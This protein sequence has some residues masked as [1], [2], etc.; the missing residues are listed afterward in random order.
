MAIHSKLFISKTLAELPTPFASPS[1]TS[2]CSR[3][4]ALKPLRGELL[5]QRRDSSGVV[6]L[7]RRNVISIEV[8]LKEMTTLGFSGCVRR[9]ATD[10][11]TG[12]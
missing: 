5:A 8:L 10:N 12:L 1:A 7:E 6:T 2:S 11:I 9:S 4:A 3:H